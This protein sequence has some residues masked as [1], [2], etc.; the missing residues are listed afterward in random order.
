[1]IT[2]LRIILFYAF[3]SFLFL[4]NIWGLFPG[5]N[6]TMV[7]LYIAPFVLFS[8]YIGSKDSIRVP[9]HLG[10]LFILFIITVL[11]SAMYA[12][13][14]Q[15]AFEY[16]LYIVSTFLIFIYAYNNA[17]LIKIYIVPFVVISS[18]LSLI[19]SSLLLLG[20]PF[21]SSITPTHDDQ[22]IYRVVSMSHYP[23]GVFV[24]LLLIVSYV[25]LR[26]KKTAL[27][28][29]AVLIFSVLLWFSY[30]RSA[31]AGILV[32]IAAGFFT[33]KV[34]LRNFRNTTLSLFIFLTTIIFFFIPLAEDRNIP[35]ISQLHSMV[36]GNE[37]TFRYKDFNNGR[38]EFIITA[39]QAIKERLITGYGGGNFYYAS[40]YYSKNMDYVVSTSHNLLIDIAAE[41]GV[42][43]LLVFLL[44]LLIVSHKVI[45]EM[46][47]NSSIN[48]VI[49]SV[50]IGL[51][52]LFQ[53]N[54]YH[55]MAFL[56]VF[57][58]ICG[59]L[60]YQERTVLNDSFAL[61]S[62]SFFVAL[63]GV[64]IL[65]ASFV[66][67]RGNPALALKLYPIYGKAYRYEIADLYKNQRFDEMVIAINAHT[68]LYENV[69]FDMSFL[70]RFHEYLGHNA[71][72]L[73][74]YILALNR[75]P[76][77]TGYVV[78]VFELM[79]VVRSKEEARS[80]I[81]N[82]LREYTILYPGM[83]F[84]DR[85]WFVD[86]CYSSGVDCYDED[87]VRNDWRWL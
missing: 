82:H 79:S 13:H 24:F 4:L 67:S 55:L 85:E 86:W 16:F 26:H 62:V 73:E 1:M 19:Y 14:I 31:Y 78:K 35:V 30:L 11:L 6:H 44:I 60:L 10:L 20:Q 64:V 56:L 40:L 83:R 32:V 46:R 87:S 23:Q 15:N 54:Y 53:F 5:E 21:V 72:A 84:E 39:L 51:L 47:K 2:K 41:N 57:F 58:F 43:S 59:A 27:S 38:I 9:Y 25:F 29:L 49:G 3:L 80:Y 65:A 34:S 7:L 66:N 22:L 50:F 71:R 61:K 74:Y 45:L 8:T 18:L 81:E 77:N 63:I 70:G 42:V 17:N 37:Q 36:V 12:V 28:I 33:G 68:A 76:R 75:A 52:V 48:N 69:P